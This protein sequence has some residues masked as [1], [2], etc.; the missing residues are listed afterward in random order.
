MAGLKVRLKVAVPPEIVCTVGV[1]SDEL[2]PLPPELDPLLPEF[3]P[4]PAEPAKLSEK[5]S[6]VNVTEAVAE[7]YVVVSDGVKVAVRV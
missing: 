7:L 5:S 4:L 1:L 6:T 2:E 3:D